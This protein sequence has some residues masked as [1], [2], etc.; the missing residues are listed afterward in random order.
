MRQNAD[1][2]RKTTMKTPMLCMLLCLL[3]VPG[4]RAAD[5]SA[6][7]RL[8]TVSFAISCAPAVRAPFNRGVALLHDFWYQEAQRQFEKIAKSDPRCAMAHWGIAM[9]VFHQL[10]DRPDAA[11]LALGWRELEL[12][13]SS[14]PKTPRERAYIGALRAFYRPDRREHQSATLAYS[15][16]MGALYARYPDDPD[17]GA[18]YALSLLAAEA[19]DDTSLSAEHN[20]LAVL[21]PLF[22]K[23]PD[24]PGIVH[25]LIHASDTPSLAAAGLAAARRYGDIAASA[26]HAAHMP[27]HIF[28]RLGMWQADIESQRASIAASQAAETRHQSGAFD[29]FH[30]YDFLLYAYLQSGEDADAQG[31]I[32]ETTALLD[33]LQDMPGMQPHGMSGMLPYYRSKY[34]LIYDLEQRNWKAAA[35]LEPVAGA[36]PETQALTY[37]ARAVAAGHLHDEKAAQD[38]LEHYDALMEQVKRGANAYLAN[39]TGARIRSGEVRAWVAFA[40][41]N[42]SD[43]VSQMHDT[44]DLQDKV[45]QGEVDIPAREMLAD[46]LSESGQ[47]RQALTEYEHALALSPNRFNGLFGAGLAAEAAGDKSKAYG[48]Y[49]ALLKSTDSGSRSSRAEFDHAKAFILGGSPRPTAQ[50][51]TWRGASP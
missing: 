48:Y 28:A 22:V 4:A 6:T 34:P 17:A 39:S 12:A 14:P 1:N 51:Q 16:A 11:A 10:W 27:G 49:T 35:A 31:V 25:Y 8:G 46:I 5:A 37:W 15:A 24:H 42:A 40:A 36:L 9:S 2:G 26:P 45:G 3:A 23:Y 50:S 38:D 13:R 30:S 18:L 43:A 20:A 47:P 41:G 29:Q 32:A 44:A 33:H 19:P 21:N 7:E